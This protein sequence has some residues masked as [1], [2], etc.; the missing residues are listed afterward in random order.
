MPVSTGSSAHLSVLGPVTVAEGAERRPPRA[1]P[2]PGQPAEGPSKADVA[3]ALWLGAMRRKHLRQVVRIETACYPRPWSSA[4]FLSELAQRGSRRYMVAMVGPLVV[5][6]AGMMLVVDEG[7]ITNVA[8]DPLWWGRGVAAWLLLDQARAAPGLG[9]AHLTLEVR[10]GNDRAQAL[11]RRFGF[12]PVG[13]RKGYYAE[14][15]E[16]AVVMWAR[17]IDTPEYRAKLAAIEA[18]LR[19]QR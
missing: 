14:T 5:G 16:D 2:A 13:V 9:V 8:V 6:Y 10:A 3:D 7:H 1:E 18:G 12:A 19:C 11:Y 17:D 15:G 4:L